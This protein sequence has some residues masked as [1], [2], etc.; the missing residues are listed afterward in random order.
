MGKYGPADSWNF[1]TFP[2]RVASGPGLTKRARRAFR[3]P[4]N[5][6]SQSR[7]GVRTG[8]EIGNYPSLPKF[9]ISLPWG[10]PPVSLSGVANLRRPPESCCRTGF[11][12]A[13]A[14]SSMVPEYAIDVWSQRLLL[15]KTAR[16]L[17]SSPVGAGERCFRLL[18]CNPHRRSCDPGSSDLN[19]RHSCRPVRHPDIDPVRVH[20]SGPPDTVDHFRRLPIYRDIYGRI[21]LDRRVWKWLARIDAGNCRAQT[22]SLHDQHLAGFGRPGSCDR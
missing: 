18:N 3:E 11:Q 20:H 13:H 2:V 5:D 14:V 4:I 15:A 7:C 9:P 8:R 16:P 22:L 10:V 19:R 6:A 21:D 17:L 1:R 12:I